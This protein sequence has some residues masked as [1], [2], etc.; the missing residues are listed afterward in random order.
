MIK[1]IILDTRELEAPEPIQLVMENLVN[2]NS[3]N[4]I[5][6]IHRMEP[7]MLYSYLLK[8]DFQYRTDFIEDDI[9]IY[10]WHD[11]FDDKN[12]KV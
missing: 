1:E 7:Q 2:L 6:M 9:F 5:K 4:Y 12:I 11:S 8:G 3:N 10:I